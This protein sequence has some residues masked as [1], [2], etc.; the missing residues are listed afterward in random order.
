MSKNKYKILSEYSAEERDWI[1]SIEKEKAKKAS[2]KNGNDD[3]KKALKANAIKQKGL[4]NIKYPEIGSLIKTPNSS[5]VVKKIDDE[6][7]TILVLNMKTKKLKTV[8]MRKIKFKEVG[9][10]PLGKP[11]I[12]PQV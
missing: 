2:T 9:K 7:G 3:F 6:N 12:E 4:E 10:T 11:I 5:S 1:S 8:D